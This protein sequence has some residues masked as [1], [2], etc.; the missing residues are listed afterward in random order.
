MANGK[1]S[2]LGMKVVF[3]GVIWQ[4]RLIIVLAVV[5]SL[6]TAVMTSVMAAMD[7]FKLAYGWVQHLFQGN[8]FMAADTDF[9]VKLVAQAISGITDF[10]LSMLL[11]ILAWGLYELFISK[12]S[13]SEST[14]QSSSNIL[15][16]RTL[17][18][19]KD[20]MIKV[21]MLILVVLFFD[22]AM[23]VTIENAASFLYLG[24]GILM[25]AMALFLSQKSNAD[26]SR[27]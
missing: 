3:E 15:V 9:R 18:D 16:I 6:L 17:D 19:L 26:H 21:V 25:V 1:S 10:L 4:S 2:T 23:Q 11:F 24:G 12:L 27:K 20:R 22:H 5:A 7:I 14:V 8:Y 13:H